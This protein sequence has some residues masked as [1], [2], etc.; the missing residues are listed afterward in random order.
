MKNEMRFR[1]A[2]FLVIL[3]LFTAQL[4][5]QMSA[6]SG[7]LLASNIIVPQSRAFAIHHQPVV[8]ITD[9]VVD[10]VIVEQVATT[11]MDIS[12][13]NPHRSRLEA[14]LIVPVPEGA[15]VRGFTFQGSASE[16]SAKLLPKAEARRIYEN[17]VA[18]V[19]DPALLEFIGYNLIRSSVFPVEAHGDQK[20]RLIYEHLLPA[21]GNRIDY[22]LPRSDSLEYTVPWKIKV[23]IKSKRPISTICSPTHQLETKRVDSNTFKV[24]ITDSA[25]TAPG[26]FRMSCLLEQNGITASLLTY[27]DPNSDGGYFLLL[28]GLPAK[29]RQADDMPT[30]KREVILVIDRSGSM[31]GEKIE[32]VREAG[33]QI[34][35]GLDNGEAFNIISYNS[36][37]NTFANTPLIKNKESIEQATNYLNNLNATGG[38]NIH[39]ALLEAL[40]MKPLE[41]MHP[42]V[43]FLTD[44]LPT[45]GQTSETAIRNVAIKSNLY[46]R[47]VFTFGVGYD[48]NA[49]LL[50]RIASETR[51]TTTFV[52]PKEDV[53]VKV[54]H[55]FKRL[56][57]PIL[58]DAKLESNPA[59]SLVR[60]SDVLPAQ[61][62]DLYEDDQLLVL[63]KYSGTAPLTFHLSGEHMGKK[64]TFQ[65]TFEVNNAT[66]RN[67][68]VPRLWASR[69]I[70]VLIDAIRQLGADSPSA[71]ASTDPK[72][73]ELVDE[74]VKLSTEFGILT[75]YTAFLAR[76]G[77]D[78]SRRD[79]VLAEANNNFWSRGMRT[80]SGIG[81]VNQAFNNIKQMKQQ[82]L[83]MRNDFYDQN[84][85]QVS[86]SN[87]QQIN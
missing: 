49:P 48:V 50:E 38:T 2:C 57:G 80:R 76:E 68:F 4:Q 82:T 81:G 86:I 22:V 46:N 21:E 20:V 6:S 12:L 64:R 15:V 44:G 10:I 47:R 51:A 52:L 75:E 17:I 61:L 72:I 32:Q 33:L 58:T 87:V 28:A 67:A 25:S 56:A 24:K 53:E 39:D 45:V 7:R 74:I 59:G 79:L 41:K 40:R 8:Q 62:P 11:T 66:T 37:V 73:T 26:A 18:K 35:A 1:L 54:A 16:P 27:P 43:L 30:V 77:T 5:A 34:L 36:E 42:L 71:T 69:K 60:T 23:K 3:P 55:V 83:N 14:E 31:R 84:M 29:P 70:G 65:F 9:V 13:H 78:L 19:R 63:G 85:K